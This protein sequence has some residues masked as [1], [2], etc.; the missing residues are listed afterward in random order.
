[1]KKL[2]HG[3][4]VFLLLFASQV[5]AQ[6][7]TITGTVTAREDGLPLPGVSVRVQGTTIGTVTGADG[8]YSITTA[9]NNI[10]VFT[11]IGYAVQ[12]ASVAGKSVINISLQSSNNQLTEVVVTALGIRREKR[13]LGYSIQEV[14]GDELVAANQSNALGALA[15]KV[16][17]VQI[18]SSGGTAGSA[19][20]IQLRGTN[21]L[22]GNNQPLFVIDGMP[23]DNSQN[24]T[25]D[26]LQGGTPI[27]R[28]A[29]INP[30][31]IESVSVLK[32]PSAAALY[33][34]RAANGAIVITTKKGVAGKVQVDF[35]AGVSFDVVNKLPKLQHEYIKGVNG[36]IP[37]NT[38][39]SRY[40]WGAKADTLFRTGVPNQFDVNGN[41]VGKSS[42]LAKIPFTPYDNLNNFFR[43]GATYNNS[44][45]VSGGSDIATYR[46]S[47]TN[48]YQTSIVPTQYY[49]RTS[50]AFSGQL[51]VSKRLKAS[52]NMTYTSSDGNIAQQGS[53][54]SGIML[55]LTRTPI[56]FDNSFGRKDPTDPA[57]YLFP[58]GTQRSY[59]N[60][61]YDNPF[62]TINQNPF[63]TN[64]NR[65]IGNIQLDYNIGSGF[66]A[67]YRLGTDDYQDNRHQYY[68]IQS[69]AFPGGRVI[70]DQYSYRSLN[71][72]LILSYTKKLGSDFQFDGKI[73]NN[74]F[75]TKLNNLYTTGDALVAPGFNNV[76]NAS[77]IIAGNLITPYRTVSAY[78]DLNLSYKS[79]LYLETTGRNDWASSLPK[80]N[81]SF[82]YPSV[83]LSFVF[84]ELGA[85]KDNSVLSFGKL[86]LSATQVGNAPGAFQTSSFYAPSSY[87]DG[88]TTGI[89]Y[90]SNG[91]ASYGLTANLGNSILK[92]EK[93]VSYEGGLQL[94]FFKN[95]L[96][97]DAT[98]YHSKG[99]DLLVN[100]PISGSTG[101]T[102]ITLNS[103]SV[104][105]NGFELSVNGTP[106]KSGNFTWGSF[107]NF[108]LNRSKVLELAP[109]VQQ[110]TLNGF[111]GTLI[112][113]LPGAPAASIYGYGYTRDNN[114]NIV[115]SDQKQV[116][117]N[118]NI[119]NVA[120]VSGYPISNTNDQK[121]IG[122]TNPRFRMGFGNTFTY[123]KVSLYGLIDWKFRGDIWDGTRGS[124]AAIGTSDLTSNRNTNKVFNGVSGHL[125]AGG[126]LVHYA[127]DGK[128]ELPG[129]GAVNVLSVPLDQTWYQ[130]NGGGFGNLNEQFIEDGSFVKLREVTL[131]YDFK[132]LIFGKSATFV[133][134]FSFGAFARNIII[135]TPYKGIDPETSLTGASQ[136]QGIDYFNNPGASSYGVNLKVRF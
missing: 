98:V 20:Y 44:V 127:A 113:Q 74:F 76:A 126:N 39:T 10:L 85:L 131:S 90:P 68:E 120:H 125:N 101:Y 40:S 25:T 130:G 16:A 99:T 89:A 7:R 37:S 73:G 94:Q 55:G 42:P 56:S 15:G 11:F 3:C 8:K 29:D 32:G 59:R 134:G 2:L 34:I 52:T 91:L 106:V 129:A 31:D 54:L 66:S 60:G 82:F 132:D 1:M 136:A 65:I 87:A 63:T 100:A 57:A 17:G 107:V 72:D 6:N 21:S 112:A 110:I 109:G 58:N 61:I 12:N 84:T 28:G 104:R 78:Y 111:T 26:P 19:T 50:V 23:I 49:Q 24:Q 92:P 118:G 122:N 53:N 95:R 108:S 83:N 64:L 124:L 38:S 93:T 41:I 102:S 69:G 22:T 51:N 97:I 14:K 71:S 123:K 67:L 80:N 48:V 128:T 36:T 47:V 5:Y 79:V 103:G 13:A 88:Y 96:G 70:D 33:G 81:D 27:N 114:N 77:T 135:W 117:A 133:K 46:A 119:T 45:A 86:R 9:N 43:T 4:V 121:I 116:D 75:G 30:D 105:N 18:T 35:N 62:W 115:V